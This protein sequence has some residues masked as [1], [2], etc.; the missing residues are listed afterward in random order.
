[1]LRFEALG[2]LAPDPEA[3]IASHY[4]P[5]RRIK[6]V[7]V[8]IGHALRLCVWPTGQGIYYGHLRDSIAGRPDEE[9]AWVL[10]S[11]A[12]GYRLVRDCAVPG[13]EPGADRPGGGRAD[14]LRPFAGDLLPGG[15]GARPADAR[16]VDRDPDR[17]GGP[18][19]VGRGWDGRIE[20]LGE[21]MDIE[22][23]PDERPGP[24]TPL[25]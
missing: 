6:L 16:R 8:S 20:L 15:G 10:V 13:L 7:V 17:P 18:G 19:G 22:A 9:A 23:S 5:D 1:M 2:D 24:A 25:P 3:T 14:A 4:G 21:T 12:I 11:V